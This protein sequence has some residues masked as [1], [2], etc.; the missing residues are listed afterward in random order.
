MP[1]P[2]VSTAL[3]CTVYL[4]DTQLAGNGRLSGAG[5]VLGLQE[6]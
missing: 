4:D 3:K 1:N 6:R 5:R 2:P